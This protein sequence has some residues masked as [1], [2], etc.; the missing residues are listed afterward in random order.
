MTQY[1]PGYQPAGNSNIRGRRNAVRSDMDKE[2][3]KEK[4]RSVM[5]RVYYFVDNPEKLPLSEHERFMDQLFGEK[6]EL[7]S[8]INKTWK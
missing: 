2:T 4:W 3:A 7:E 8:V 1:N 6:R 5:K